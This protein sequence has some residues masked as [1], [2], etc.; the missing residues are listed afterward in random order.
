MPSLRLT[1]EL[2]NSLVDLRRI[3]YQHEVA[4]A[5]NL[6]GRRACPE[7]SQYALSRLCVEADA[8]ILRTVQ[9]ERG[10]GNRA[11]PGGDLLFH[12]GR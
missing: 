7:K 5:I 11:A 8:A 3:F 6:L 12:S 4:Y 10:L 2:Q 1:Q 9:V